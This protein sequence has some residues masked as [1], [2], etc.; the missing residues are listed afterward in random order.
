[1]QARNPCEL[2][3]LQKAWHAPIVTKKKHKIRGRA[4]ENLATLREMPLR[5]AE[6]P[7]IVAADHEWLIRSGKQ[8]SV[9][10][11]QRHTAEFGVPGLL[12]SGS[13]EYCG[14]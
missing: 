9:T 3:C 4:Q 8:Q 1:M 6:Q 2:F 11:P 7:R 5:E 10:I 12:P 13:V 14:L